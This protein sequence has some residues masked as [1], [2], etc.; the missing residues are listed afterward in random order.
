[1][2]TGTLVNLG[3][4]KNKRNGAINKLSRFNHF[5]K[6]LNEKEI[7]VVLDFRLRKNY[8][9]EW[10]LA[11]YVYKNLHLIYMVRS[12]KLSY[13]FPGR[14]TRTKNLFAKASSI[15][16]VSKEIE[17]KINTE[18][19]L[20][21]TSFIQNPVDFEE[22]E[23]LATQNFN[24]DQ[25]YILAAG[26][27]SLD[28]KQFD[29]L[30]MTYAQSNL[31][32]QGIALKII[33]DGKLKKEY[34]QLA[35]A[36]RVDAM[37]H[38]E[39]YVENPFSY[40]KNALFTVLCSKFEGSPRVLIESLACGTPVIAMNCPTGPS[41]LITNKKNGLLLPENDFDALK[42]ALNDF[43]ENEELRQICADNARSSVSHHSLEQVGKSWQKLLNFAS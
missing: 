38:F 2:Y 21:N 5:K 36:L 32:Q 9:K 6:F 1:P 15:N 40:F 3:L 43:S 14:G 30:I 12:S 11:N 35:K 29:K 42:I 23:K 4:L 10:L 26:R 17:K 37:V 41:E 33:G 22:M 28:I 16:C 13:Y 34:R 7:D 20:K 27:M 39:G 24:E 18:Y 8:F 25:S 19:G 31:P